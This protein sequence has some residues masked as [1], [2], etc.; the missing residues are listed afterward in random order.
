MNSPVL[1][2]VS[3]LERVKLSAELAGKVKVLATE[4]GPLQ[5]IQVAKQVADILK[6]LGAGQPAKIRN[7]GW[8]AVKLS[9][10]SLEDLETLRKQVQAE[11]ANPRDEKGGY[12]EGG[13]PSLYLYDKKG[14]W[15]LD[16]LAWAVTYKQQE[17][18]KAEEAG[19]QPEPQPAQAF[20]SYLNRN[21]Y[22]G[23]AL[24][25]D[26]F[27]AG[28]RKGSRYDHQGAGAYLTT[29]RR[30]FAR[31]FARQAAD[32]L[33]NSA[34][35]PT[36]EDERILEGG[37]VILGVKIASD[38]NVLDATKADTDPALLAMINDVQNGSKTR[39]FVLAAGFDG[40][41]FV[42]PNFPD[43]WPVAA[44][45]VTIVMY[46][47]SKAGITGYEEASKVQAVTMD[48]LERGEQK[49]TGRAPAGGAVGMNGEFYKGGTFLP[50]TTLPKQGKAAGGGG[51]SG[52]LIEPGVT[53]GAPSPQAQSIFANYREFI[54]VD[55][56]VARVYERPDAAVEAMV[57]PDVAE[58]RAFLRAAADAY[59]RGMRW[60]VPGDIQ[61]TDEHRIDPE[62]APELEIVEHV[63]KGGKGKT[64]RGIIRRDLS[65]A[66]AKEIDEYTFKKDGGYFIR[67]KH[68]AGYVPPEGIRPPKPNPE[69]AP[70][71]TPEQQAQAEADRIANE[72]ALQQQR[73]E[74]QVARLRDVAAST[75]ER[76][77]ASINQDRNT[78]TARR[79]RMAASG[80]ATAE[81]DRALAL[82]INNLAD[83]IERGQAT[84]LAGITSKAAVQSLQ[85]SLRNA[86]YEA[87][88]GLS[89]REQEAQ[90]GRA[91][92]AADV[93][94]AKFPMPAWGTAGTSLSKV[95]EAIKGK[96]GSVELAKAMRFSPGPDAAMVA[97]LKAMVGDK[98]MRYLIGW[99]NLEQVAKVARLKR[100]GINNTEDLKAALGEY[101]EFRTGARQ[102]DPIKAAERAIIGQKV[103]IDFFPTPAATAVRMA[104]LARIKEGDR[105]LEPSAGNGNLADAAK[106]A[107]GVVDVIEISSQLR[108][109]LK[110]K[111]YNV[112]AFDF[113]SFMPD[114]KYDAIVMNPPFSNRQDA[115][116]IQRAYG[117]LK[118]GGRLVAIAGEGVFF[119]SDAKAVQFRSWLDSVG[120][121]VEGLEQGT[122]KDRSLLATT[123]ANARLI[124][125][126]K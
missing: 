84:H 22:H 124:V 54:H 21:A 34:N 10:L 28:A 17:A 8:D 119:G 35:P 93:Q 14:R 112:V 25:F 109:I 101:L 67:E 115:A 11:H 78:N 66:E 90:K 46:D 36:G 58:G 89:Y 57:N 44:G 106:A 79:A 116:H 92:T 105:V 81:A 95:L 120:A 15:K 27:Q 70:E 59:N 114:E 5:R 117:M 83:A 12:L 77:E 107:G 122:F 30:G 91:P 100:A 110:A 47:T 37:G 63:T 108:E 52:V 31:F 9:D 72:Q 3:A 102:E 40:I 24:P 113:D 104:N 7:F 74:Q 19:G 33:L 98:E 97:A 49:P 65:Y 41:A 53:A 68:L 29:D 86:M 73:I 75:L 118:A 2:A 32:N 20:P 39:E 43:G 1:D 71:L 103:G 82:T 125:I 76:A 60:Y 88:R 6:L 26:S 16:K 13:Q 51:A 69:P 55:G 50:N 42:E 45:A 38:A 126:Q 4:T 80:I 111:G 64:I 121:E 48:E 99:W 18:R 62:P 94:H 87:E 23:T 96:K 123:G 61:V 85:D 56:G